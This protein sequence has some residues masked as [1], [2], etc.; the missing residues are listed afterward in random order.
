MTA[1]IRFLALCSVL[2]LGACGGS[3][4]SGGGGTKSQQA[5]SVAVSS[6]QVSSAQVLSSSS[7]SSLAIPAD[8]PTGVAE[9]L[10]K[11]SLTTDGGVAIVSKE[12]YVTGQF[13]LEGEGSEPLSGALEI[14][15][16][17]NSTWGWPKKPYRIKLASSTA[18]LGMPA[19]RHWVLLANYADKTLIRNDLTFMFSKSLG[20]EYTPRAQHVEVHLNGA[21]QGVYQLVEHIRVGKDRVNIPELKVGDTDADKITGGYLLEIDFRYHKDYCKTAFW[22]TFCVNGENL[23]RQVDFCIDSNHGMDPF[24]LQSPESLHD[25]AW[26]AQRNYIETYFA[27]TEAALFGVDFKD[28]VKGY[29][30]YLDVDSLVNYY[31]INELFKNPDGTSASAYVY[32]KRGGK[33]FFGPVWDFDLA[34]GNAGYDDVDKTYGWRTRNSA[35]FKRLFEDP[36]FEAK[37]KARWQALKAEGMFE[38]LF[39]YADARATW[40]DKQ[41]K[42]N[43]QIWSITDFAS[44]ILHGTHGGTGSYEAEVKELIRWQRARYEWMDGQLGK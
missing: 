32:K 38:L 17:G 26:S 10:P 6:A 27:D 19:N 21:Y 12:D 42:A 34:L 25:P 22:E 14:R 2:T 37:V 33:F 29:A 4:S 41:Q 36:A 30:A 20:M 7:A 31:L 24:C 15:G 44:W 1:I 9:S 39:I 35:W 5:T 13:N 28:P 8:F 18:L 16:R 3:G 43:Y 11:L 23:N 40:L